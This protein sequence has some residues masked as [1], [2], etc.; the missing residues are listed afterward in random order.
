MNQDIKI[1]LVDDHVLLR[2]GLV[3]LIAKL[4]YKVIYE[5]CNG[6]DLINQI[7]KHELPDVILMDINMPIMDG[8]SATFW[9]KNNYPNIHVIALTMYDDDN[10][11]IRMIKNGAKGFILKDCEPDQLK[12][13]IHSI[14]T[15]GYFY[16]DLLTGKLIHSIN[17]MN[18]EDSSASGL[19]KLNEK[20]ITFLK[21]VSTEMTY[22][23]IAERM[24]YS[25]RTID[26]FRD[27]LFEKLNIK[28]RVGLV[29]YAIKNG[30][31]HLD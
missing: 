7:N 25:P 14:M 29:I 3:S 17:Q 10:A 16:S 1:V 22:K 27:Q 24:H 28:S 13:A 31:V 19:L 9:L 23:Q 21:L 18:D 15:K 2:K 12:Q 6:Q 20:E 8:Y 26:G 30:I 11:V 4:S 5:C